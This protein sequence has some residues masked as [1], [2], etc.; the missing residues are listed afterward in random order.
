MRTSSLNPCASS[1]SVA[2]C[3]HARQNG[4]EPEPAVLIQLVVW[5]HDPAGDL[6]GGGRQLGCWRRRECQTASLRQ[7]LAQGGQAAAVARARISANSS[8]LPVSGSYS[9]RV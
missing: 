3:G 5:A 2:S 1:V 8:R 7:V 6:P 4:L 9:I